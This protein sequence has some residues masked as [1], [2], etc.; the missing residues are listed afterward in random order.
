MPPS[1]FMT[2]V[3]ETTFAGIP[4]WSSL[5]GPGGQSVTYA[6]ILESSTC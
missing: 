5:C 4:L 3:Q 1:T 6:A 2:W